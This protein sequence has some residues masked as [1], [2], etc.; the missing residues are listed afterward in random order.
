MQRQKKEKKIA[1]HDK[2]ST[3]LSVDS[4]SKIRLEIESDA[5]K[6]AQYHTCNLPEINNKENFFL[7]TRVNT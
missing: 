5:S 7:N 6:P 3:F 2:I 4:E 1:H